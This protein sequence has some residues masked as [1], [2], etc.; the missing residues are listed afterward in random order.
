MMTDAIE[1]RR[2]RFSWVAAATADGASGY[3]G[4]KPLRLVAR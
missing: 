1:D 3:H 2:P 4:I